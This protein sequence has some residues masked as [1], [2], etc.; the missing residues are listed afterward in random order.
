M[1]HTFWKSC[2]V[3]EP[4]RPDLDGPTELKRKDDE[5]APAATRPTHLK[6]QPAQGKTLHTTCQTPHSAPNPS[7]SSRIRPKPD[8][9]LEPTTIDT[10][11]PIDRSP[12]EDA[13]FARLSCTPPCLASAPQSVASSPRQLHQRTA[14]L[15]RTLDSLGTRRVTRVSLRA[16]KLAL[17]RRSNRDERTQPRSPRHPDVVKTP[18]GIRDTAHPRPSAIDCTVDRV[19]VARQLRY[20]GASCGWFGR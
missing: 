13:R 7:S 19:P 10:A 12:R 1:K 11:R 15:A 4:R 16:R 17:T 18:S 2:E 14:R 8:K 6:S 5:P 9:L 3:P 20:W